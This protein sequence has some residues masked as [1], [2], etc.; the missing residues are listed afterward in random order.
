M[1]A[2]PKRLL[3][4]ALAGHG[5]ITPTLPLVAEL[6]RRGFRVDYATGPEHADAVAA[7][8]ATWVALPPLE[9]FTP[10]AEIGPDAI[11][12]WLRHYFA[13][14]RAAY[15]VLRERCAAEPPDAV[16]YD[17]TNWPAR[18]A[19]AELGIPA[20]RCVPN[21]ASN[22]T[23]SVD[24]R[25]TAGIAADHPEMAALREDCARFSAEYG[26]HVDFAATM[27]VTEALNLVF[28]PREFQ[29]AGESFDERFHFL[30]PLLGDREQEQ[31]WSPPG[32]AGPAD[33][34]LYI[35]LGT[36]LT[37]RPE[38]YRACVDAFGDGPWRVAMTV[39]GLDPAALGPI[40]PAVDVRPWFPQPAVLRH[41]AAFVS[42]AG[43]NS[44]MEALYYGVPLVT[45]PQ[46]PEQEA[47]ADRVRELGLGERLDADAAT[48]DALRAAVERVVSDPAV[49]AN[50]ESMRRAVRGAGGAA[51][52]ADLIEAHLR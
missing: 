26:V 29:F 17:E 23:Y 15:P 37:D 42:H 1:S 2:A 9:P 43:M 12:A 18:V 8:G 50:V 20:V 48:A 36:I 13:A 49:R 16:C 3:F 32:P 21:L 11:A 38:F 46:T 41:A 19:A 34:V 4:V 47:N 52:G 22:G 14:M 51:R 33:P 27:D 25:L 45:V 5:H 10:P 7:A 6:R 35:S 24:D 39:G 44:T 28:V 31:P 30:G 40:P